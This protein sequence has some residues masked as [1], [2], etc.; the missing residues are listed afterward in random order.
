VV[1][2]WLRS[3]GQSMLLRTACGLALALGATV[4]SAE[5]LRPLFTNDDYPAEAARERREGTVAFHAVIG[6]DGR[7]KSCV[8]IQS[9]GW[10]D[11]DQTTCRLVIE[12]LWLRP[13]RDSDGRLVEVSFTSKA[14]WKLRK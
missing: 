9:S 8:V 13:A 1:I 14:S 6:K 7:A 11:L 3:E 10:Q 4:I 12:R 2:G 5:R